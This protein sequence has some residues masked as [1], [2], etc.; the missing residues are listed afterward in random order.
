MTHPARLFVSVS[1]VIAC[2][3]LPS[4]PQA[5]NGDVTGAG[6]VG[7]TPDTISVNMFSGS[8]SSSYPISV[9]PGRS[10][11]QPD[12]TVGYN[13]G[14]SAN[15]FLGRGWDIAF[16]FIQR[17]TRYGQPTFTWSDTFAIRWRGQLLDLIMICDPGSGCP[18]GVREF[19]TE[20][21]TFMRIKSYSFPPALTYWEVEDGTGRKY[22]FGREC[23]L[24][25]GL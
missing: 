24:Q 25:T 15:G 6:L 21:E 17:S 7:S 23:P 13:S 18:Q 9:P 22:Q 10:G 16:P 3:A 12:I 8:A 4:G 14:A 11:L 5:A 19:R 1:L 20:I 2:V